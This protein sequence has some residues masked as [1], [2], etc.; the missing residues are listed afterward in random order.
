M[1]KIYGYLDDIIEIESN[2]SSDEISCFHKDV[3]ITLSDG[4]KIKFAYLNGL[5]KVFVISKGNTRFHIDEAMDTDSDNYSDIFTS[6]AGVVGI[7]TSAK[8]K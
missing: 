1:V 4:T 5:W 3:F 2:T 8:S 7:R 6:E